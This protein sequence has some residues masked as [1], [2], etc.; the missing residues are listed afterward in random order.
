M[1]QAFS[2]QWH[3]AFSFHKLPFD[4]KCVQ[5]LLIHLLYSDVLKP[6]YPFSALLLNEKKLKLKRNLSSHYLSLE[7]EN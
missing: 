4:Y 6:V 1:P 5:H 7:C 3:L 2:N